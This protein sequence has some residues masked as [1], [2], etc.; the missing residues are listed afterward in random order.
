MSETAADPV[1]VTLDDE[2]L[3]RLATAVA[4]GLA[5]YL[6]PGPRT[7]APT[8]VTETVTEPPEDGE[9]TDP[10]AGDGADTSAP[11]EEVPLPAD[12]ATETAPTDPAS[13]EE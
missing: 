3:A 2:Q 7:A 11:T 6:A 5:E 9:P 10:E 13:A 8:E 4:A 1:P 12:S